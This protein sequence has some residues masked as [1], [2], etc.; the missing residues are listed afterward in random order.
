MNVW[1]GSTRGRERQLWS[2]RSSSCVVRLRKRGYD[3]PGPPDRAHGGH[4]LAG[5]RGG[6]GANGHRVPV[7]SA[8]RPHKSVRPP[9]SRCSTTCAGALSITILG[10]C[11]RSSSWDPRRT[12][13]V[14]RVPGAA[15]LAGWSRETN[16]RVDVG[17]SLLFTASS[18]AALSVWT[19]IG[20]GSGGDLAGVV[21]LRGDCSVR[22]F[23]DGH[24]AWWCCP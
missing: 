1:P 7:A 11:S 13:I 5:G 19:T 2:S 21:C 16:V 3:H 20:A 15:R 17:V 23:R 14:E 18:A 9:R 8:A 10:R 22:T 12:G 4:E 6:G 24:D